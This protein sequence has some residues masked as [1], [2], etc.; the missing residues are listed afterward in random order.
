VAAGEPLLVGIDK[1]TSIVKTAVFDRRGRKLAGSARR[2]AAIHPHPGAHEEDPDSTWSLTA[3]TIRESMEQLGE[4]AADIVGVGVV[5]HMG[6]AWFV[7]RD[8]RSVRNSIAWP[9]ARA[10]GVMRA[11]EAGGDHDEYL[12]LTATA[13]LPGMTGL[14]LAHLQQTE[15]E[16]IGRTYRVLNA[17]DF[18]QLRL[19]GA[20]VSEPSDGSFVP[21]DIDAKQ[22]AHRALEILGAETWFD[23]LPEIVPSGQ[24]IGQVSEA[25]SATTGLPQ[26]VMVIAGLGDAPASMIGCGAV[27]PGISVSVLGT[28]WLSA[29]VVRDPHGGRFGIGWMY[30]MPN[31]NFAHFVANTSGAS[32]LD[33]WLERMAP[34][35]IDGDSRRFDRLEQ[36]I[37]AVGEATTGLTFLPYLSAGGVQAPFKDLDLRGTLFG[38]EHSTTRGE[39]FRAVY[40]GMAYSVKDCYESFGTPPTRV[41]LTGGGAASAIWPV[42]LSNLL[43]V[44]IDLPASDEAAA[45]GVAILAGTRAGVWSSLEEGVASAVHM[46]STI[47]PDTALAAAHAGAFDRFKRAQ[48]FAREFYTETAKGNPEP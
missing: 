47:E 44:P 12:R 38:M 8:G 33:W 40:E 45:L 39:V 9:D 5:G 14:L 26:G 41:R 13:A 48:Q 27:E 11:L 2:I 28:S 6:G 43:G 23:R 35:V 17:K 19:C 18:I 25:A 20:M 42:V 7:D 10:T 34:D 31:G 4:R 36:E 15:P 46:A 1:G 22:H 21:F 24:A 32:T 37:L 29:N 30:P 16:L 3:E